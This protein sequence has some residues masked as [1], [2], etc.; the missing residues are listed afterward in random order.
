MELEPDIV[1]DRQLFE[2][3]FARFAR[4]SKGSMEE[5]LRNQARLF[6][7]DAVHVTPPF[8]QG[9]GQGARVAFATGKKSIKRN[10]DKLFIGRTLVGER[11][12]THLFG[13]TDVPGLPY[14]VKT[15]EKFPDVEGIYRSAK[16]SARDRARNGLR[17][18]KRK[19]PVSRRKVQLIYNREIKKVGFLAGGWNTAADKLG[20]ATKI[21]AFVRRH[22]SAP[23]RLVVDF[24]ARTLKISMINYVA[25][26]NKVGN[27]ERRLAFALRK[28]TDAMR[29]QIPRL[30]REAGRAL[31]AP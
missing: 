6:I 15:T 20:A 10:L 13:K 19:L 14:V 22:G 28:R 17:M 16:K 7:I 25:Y 12:I 30:L 5:E 23:G 9:T 31:Q 27:M 1:L 18:D 29:L 11:Q 3:T 24:S 8:H 4:L 2:E 21:P 26:A